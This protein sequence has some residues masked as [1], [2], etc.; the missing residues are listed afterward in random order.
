MNDLLNEQLCEKLRVVIN[1]TDIFIK[2]EDESKKFLFI[3]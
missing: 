1:E 2:D 3:N